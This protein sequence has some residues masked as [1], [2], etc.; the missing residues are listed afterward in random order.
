MAIRAGE[1]GIPAVVG[2]GTKRFEQYRKA[3]ILEIN[4]LAKN[5]RILRNR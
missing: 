1:L 2:V 4:A 5:V 3:E